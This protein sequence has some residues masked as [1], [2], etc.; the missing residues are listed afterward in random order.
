MKKSIFTLFI[1]LA[2]VFVSCG[3]TEATGEA[4]S[5]TAYVPADAQVYIVMKTSDLLDSQ[6]MKKVTETLGSDPM[7][8]GFKK[9]KELGIENKPEDVNTIILFSK[10][11]SMNID[12]ANVGIA[13]S[14]NNL[15]KEGILKALE[16]ENGLGETKEYKG[17]TYY[18]S[19][20]TVFSMTGDTLIASNS[21]DVIKTMIDTEDGGSN[22]SS[23][24]EMTAGSS[25]KEVFVS[26]KLNDT[27]KSSISSQVPQIA[28][29]ELLTITADAGEAMDLSIKG[30]FNDTQSANQIKSMIDGVVAMQTS[31]MPPAVREQIESVSIEASASELTISAKITEETIAILAPLVLGGLM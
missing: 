19:R 30:M 12:A 8:E 11:Y 24:S 18:I 2:L 28:N 14:V 3:G 15:D 7:E 4:S 31:R 29:M 9:F 5:L 1:V 21:E 13:A 16:D 6:I 26:M 17:L 27:F 20:D 25:G 10:D 23:M 22:I